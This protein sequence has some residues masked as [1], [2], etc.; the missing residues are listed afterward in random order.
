MLEPICDEAE[1]AAILREMVT[2]GAPRVFAVVQEYGE[3]SDGRIAAW[4]MA[5][6]EHAEVVAV[7]GGLRM[8]VTSPENALRC[9]GRGETIRPRLVWFDPA[10]PGAAAR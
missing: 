9:F 7:D 5:F 2:A 8:N 3:R 6:A 4:G 1:F 10:A